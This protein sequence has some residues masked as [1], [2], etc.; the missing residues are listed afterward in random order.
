[1]L[2][3][4]VE[5]DTV[6]VATGAGEAEVVDIMDTYSTRKKKLLVRTR[7]ACVSKHRAKT[8]DRILGRLSDDQMRILRANKA[9]AS[10]DDG[11]NAD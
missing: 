10:A 1:M 3:D 7:A 4:E 9:T 2:P 8:T 5:L 6:L 11:K